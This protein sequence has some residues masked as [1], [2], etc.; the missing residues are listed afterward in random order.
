MACSSKWVK[1]TVGYVGT[2]DGWRDIRQHGELKYKY[3]TATKRNVACN[4]EIESQ[5]KNLY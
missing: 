5:K 2:S 3:D 1:R 4:G